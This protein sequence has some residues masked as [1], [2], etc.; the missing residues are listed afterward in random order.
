MNRKFFY[1]PQLI[2][3]ILATVSLQTLAKQEQSSVASGITVPEW[4]PEDSDLRILE[5]RT[6]S[7]YFD[8]VI[9]AYHYKDVILIPL[10]AL[11]EIIEIAITSEPGKRLAHGYIFKKENSFYLD[12]DQNTVTLKGVPQAYVRDLIQ[13]LPDDIYIESSLISDWLPIQLEVD[14]FAST[15]KISSEKMLPFERRL[16]REKRIAKTRALK[17]LHKQQYPIHKDPYKLWN[18]P[19]IDQSVQANTQN[20]NDNSSTTLSYKIGRAHV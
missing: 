7:H 19:F 14:L 17:K 12:L 4:N 5:I 10:G 6:A 20:V 8:D 13:V 9:T 1:L 15:L 16:D 3:L 18:T 2:L 11:S